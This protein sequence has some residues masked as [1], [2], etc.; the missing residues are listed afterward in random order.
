MD[1]KILPKVTIVSVTFNAQNLIE[2][3]ILSVI[4]QDYSNLEYIIID[5]ASKDNTTQIIEKYKSQIDYFI[6]EK[7]N[8]IYDAMNK[9]I[10]KASG[11]WIN[12]MNAGDSFVD[13]NIIS[14]VMEEKI[15]DYDLIY[16]ATYEVHPKSK[17]LI[18]AP[19]KE[20]MLSYPAMCHQSLFVRTEVQKKY[21]YDTTYKI[22]ADYE[23]EIKCEVLG[24]RIKRVEYPISNFLTGGLNSKEL[25]RTRIEGI[26]ILL[27]Y[28]GISIAQKSRMSQRLIE[29]GCTEKLPTSTISESFLEKIK[30]IMVRK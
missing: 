10:E 27:R 26:S 8:G 30:K 28:K 16:G 7:D 14:R 22:C 20:D 4:N 19:I 24:Y 2:D 3:T 12:F 15:Q 25:Y 11:D 13:N 1:K 17:N 9:G 23:F 5:G 21:P 29:E 18:P 6:S